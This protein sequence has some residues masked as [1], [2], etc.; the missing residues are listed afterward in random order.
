MSHKGVVG[1]AVP[2][3]IASGFNW[4]MVGAYTL[5][6]TKHTGEESCATWKEL[7]EIYVATPTLNPHSFYLV[8]LN[9]PD[10]DGLA[11]RSSA[12]NPAARVDSQGNPYPGTVWNSERQRWEHVAWFY[13]TT[14]M[15]SP[16]DFGTHHV[17]AYLSALA[18]AVDDDYPNALE[19]YERVTSASNYQPATTRVEPEFMIMPRYLP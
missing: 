2:G 14:R 18:Y 13:Y 19:A 6:Y 1:M 4:R 9:D 17:D 5:P 11:L 15:N 7:Y 3:R 16:A 12:G 8:T 10:A